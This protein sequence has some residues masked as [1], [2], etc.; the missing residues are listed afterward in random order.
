MWYLIKCKHHYYGYHDKL[1]PKFVN[2]MIPS[3][4]E[5]NCQALVMKFDS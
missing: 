5:F 1:K 3:S 2:I 4:Q